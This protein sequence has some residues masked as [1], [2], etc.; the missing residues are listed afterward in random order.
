MARERRAWKVG[1]LLVVLAAGCAHAEQPALAWAVADIDYKLIV[2]ASDDDD[3][4]HVALNSKSRRP[5]CVDIYNWPDQHGRMSPTLE[6]SAVVD[7]K[8]FEAYP[9]PYA[10]L[11]MGAACVLRVEPGG[12]LGAFIGYEQFGDRAAISAAKTKTLTMSVKAYF[13]RR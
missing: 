6:A 5:L 8:R 7:D 3:G 9:S 2:F 12:S 11:C 1:M 13:C 10:D 4:F